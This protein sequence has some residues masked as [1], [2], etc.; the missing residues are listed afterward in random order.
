MTAKN[1]VQLYSVQCTLGDTVLVTL[2]VPV[3]EKC[4]LTWN[5]SS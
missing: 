3:I 2:V 5:N 1:G 4:H